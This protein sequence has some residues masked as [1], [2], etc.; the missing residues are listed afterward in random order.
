MEEGKGVC[1]LGLGPVGMLA[2][3]AALAYGAAFVC[4]CDIDPTAVRLAHASGVEPAVNG[5][6]EAMK[7]AIPVGRRIDVVID[8]VG[9]EETIRNG[10]EILSKRG[11][12]TL[13]AVHNEAIKFVP[14]QLNGERIVTTSANNRY[15]DFPAAIELLASGKVKVNHLITHHF[16]LSEA[17]EAF[18]VMEH[19][20]DED[21]FKV[22]LHPDNA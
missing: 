1:V 8:T 2:G 20:E 22:V 5:N 4:G 7:K 16:P 9:T 6:P 18:R 3:L 11:V 12:H 21:A 10:L 15:K 14:L 19:K 17:R 13:L